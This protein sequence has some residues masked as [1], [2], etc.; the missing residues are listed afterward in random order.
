[1]K[2]F[3]TSLLF[4][5]SLCSVVWGDPPKASERPLAQ[6]A[7]RAEAKPAPQKRKPHFTVSKETTYVTKPL[8][9]DGYIDYAAALHERLHRGVTP[10][11]NAVVL[12]W[13]AFGPHPEG[14]KMPEQF[15][16]WLEIDAPPERG[17]YFIALGKF[18]KERR[19]LDQLDWKDPIFQEQTDCSQ[20]SW[21]PDQ[22][23]DI[24]AWLKANE[25][26][27]ALV[28]EASK[29][30]QYYSPLVPKRTEKKGSSGLF[31]AL[32][33]GVQK[34]RELANALTIR[35]M[36]HLGEGRI[37]DA[38]RDL[39]ACHRLGRLVGRGP[40]LIE[41]L[42]G[43]AIDS[44]AS[45]AEL[46]FLADADLK[47]ERIRK[48]LN[49][50]RKLPPMPSFVDKIDVC[51]RFMFL[52][53]VMMVERNGLKTLEGLAD[54]TPKSSSFLDK[55][56]SF[57]L[58][59]SIDWDPS[60]RTAN[61]WYDRVA[62]A[63]R[64]EDFAERRKQLDEIDKE[65]KDLTKKTRE[66]MP[67]PLQLIFGKESSKLVS[68]WVSNV[69]VGLLMPAFLKVQQARDRGDQVQANLYLAFALAAY[70]RDNGSYPK[71]LEALMPKY[72]DKIPNDLFSGKPLVYK[73]GEKGY[74]LYSV[75]VNGRD[76][77][78]RSWE[79]A[80]SADDLRVR[81][82]LPKPSPK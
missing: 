55:I 4:L 19:K 52:D 76:D 16:K 49:D 11:N 54:G 3:V 58:Q 68:E 48:C 28:I 2:K 39:L 7:D 53:V 21:K 31:G 56:T 66:S 26:P 60:M 29:R 82:P 70:R 32:L 43:I 36:L 6:P 62:K 41:G 69:L 67:Q 72:M 79:D 27:L 35:A 75:G 61:R 65:L 5:A 10:D 80:P 30:S 15:F 77:G 51:E 50:L 46:V 64:V 45:N 57:Y 81:M 59:T 73:P 78:G 24:A 34:C 74:L 63:L 37:D 23:P 22:H 1:M 42:V 25:K 33:P 20:R 9:A 44:I 13:K 71:N 40:T 47:T 18:V 14:A 12:L 17:D 38:W 8:D